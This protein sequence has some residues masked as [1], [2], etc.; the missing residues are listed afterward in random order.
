MQETIKKKAFQAVTSAYYKV[1]GDIG[2]SAKLAALQLGVGVG[3][4]E[5]QIDSDATKNSRSESDNFQFSEKETAT[6]MQ[7]KE[8][9]AALQEVD[10]V[11]STKQTQELISS[12]N[13]F[14]TLNSF[15]QN[16]GV[17]SSATMVRNYMNANNCSMADAMVALEQA[18]ATKDY[19]TISQYVGV[20]DNSG[21]NNTLTQPT[22]TKYFTQ[23]IG[24]IKG[25]H[26]GN[27]GIVEDSAKIKVV[28]TDDGREIRQDGKIA[29]FYTT[30]SMG[31]RKGA[32]ERSGIDFNTPKPT[33]ATLKASSQLGDMTD[34]TEITQ[35][36]KNL[37]P[38]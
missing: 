36:S 26:S 1:T 21:L 8:F 19:A 15:A 27:V 25:I 24:N 10:K 16:W 11:N 22:N 28:T 18:A 30:S 5:R 38:T 7:N 3:Y 13:S 6:L 35:S 14:N 23:N 37:N 29:D 31:I 32:A 4:D 20:A 9:M 2:I 34:T 33:Q 12:A 17:D